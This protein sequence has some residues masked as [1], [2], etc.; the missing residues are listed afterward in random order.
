[1]AT[2]G[3]AMIA[4]NE[5]KNITRALDSVK[6]LI[7]CA[8]VCDTGST[9]GTQQIVLDWLKD[10]SVIG[11]VV[12]EPWE[13]F[14]VNR[15]HAL[16]NLR[17]IPMIDYTLMVDADEVVQITAE[18]AAL[19]ARLTADCYSLDIHFGTVVYSAPR[20]TKNR[21]PFYYRGPAH[22]W[23]DC[24][25]QFNK[26]Y[27]AGI[28]LSGPGGRG[29]VSR[30]RTDAALLAQELLLDDLTPLERTRYTFYL[31]QSYRDCGEP[32]MAIET[33][34]KRV[35]L[36]GWDEEVYIALLNI[37]RLEKRFRLIVNTY[38]RAIAVNPKRAEAIHGA[39][40]ALRQAGL[41]HEAYAMAERGVRLPLWKGLFVEPWVYQYALLDEF[42]ISSYYTGNLT[43]G[44]LA[45][46]L[47]LRDPTL[48]PAARAHIERNAKWFR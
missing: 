27:L 32:V 48:D 10:N 5:A 11:D 16:A 44:W 6:P 36:G 24:R 19:K 31:A 20:L 37:A 23:L 38:K 18:P 29:D 13:S 14:G 9:D 33:Y 21:L 4:K 35:A 22:E 47:L 40:Q 2:I 34:E 28:S 3:L 15:S 46:E 12:E 42:L 43:A 17:T 7:D 41:Y 8:I 45:T 30:Y 26:S 39:A 25:D 1:M